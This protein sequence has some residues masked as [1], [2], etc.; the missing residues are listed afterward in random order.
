MG[1]KGCPVLN[2][3]CIRLIADLKPRIHALW[4]NRSKSMYGEQ[5]L[6]R[7]IK[8]TAKQK[9]ARHTKV[10]SKT[11]VWSTRLDAGQLRDWVGIPSVV[12]FLYPYL[13]LTFLSIQVIKDL[14]VHRKQTAIPS[15]LYEFKQTYT[16]LGNCRPHLQTVC[17]SRHRDLSLTSRL[18]TFWWISIIRAMFE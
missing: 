5:I 10:R 17:N 13:N 8:R 11:F 12:A 16:V 4:S 14:S 18:V 6:L 3:I 7:R 1:Q 2:R 15:K 9:A